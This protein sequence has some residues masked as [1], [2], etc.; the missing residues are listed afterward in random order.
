MLR[1]DALKAVAPGIGDALVVTNLANTA[2]EWAHAAP[3]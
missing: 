2:T 1:Y 3:A